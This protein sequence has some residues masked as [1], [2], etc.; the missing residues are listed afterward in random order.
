MS[1]SFLQG[2][3]DVFCSGQLEG[4]SVMYLLYLLCSFLA[5]SVAPQNIQINTLSSTQLEVQWEPPPAETQ[6]GIIQ[7]YKV[8]PPNHPPCPISLI[9]LLSV[10]FFSSPLTLL[11]FQA[12]QAGRIATICFFRLHFLSLYS[13]QIYC[14]RLWRQTVSFIKP[15]H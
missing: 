5:P 8:T 1:A 10:L 6:N 2:T 4:L 12:L 14:I 9:L 15:M 13:P 11:S 3:V 7:G